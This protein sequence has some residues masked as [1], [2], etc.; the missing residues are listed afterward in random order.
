MENK[1]IGMLVAAFVCLFVG[2][3]LIGVISNGLISNTN[4]AYG[5][6]VVNYGNSVGAG[7]IINPNA[8][9]YPKFVNYTDTRNDGIRASE[10]CGKSAVIA[11]ITVYNTTSAFTAADYVIQTNGS[12]QYKAGLVANATSKVSNNS[13]LYY[14]YCEDSYVQSGWGKT[15]LNLIPGFFALALLACSL[16][17][18]Y[19]V[20]KQTGIM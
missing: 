13:I 8:A 9:Y 4:L 17:L 1:I 3:S 16:G 5:S 2:L 7:G 18:F 12:I 10:E 20:A 11:S 15:M 6:E 19:G 14:R